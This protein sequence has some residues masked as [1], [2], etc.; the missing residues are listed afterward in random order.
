MN[1]RS[2]VDRGSLRPE[3]SAG[4]GA[5]ASRSCAVRRPSRTSENGFAP[6]SRPGSGHFGL[7]MRLAR[8]S[9][10]IAK[11]GRAE[12]RERQGERESGRAVV[13]D[14]T[15]SPLAAFNAVDA[16]RS[17]SAAGR[18]CRSPGWNRIRLKKLPQG[19][20][21]AARYSPIRASSRS[22]LSAQSWKPNDRALDGA[23]DL[24]PGPL[25]G[26]V[27]IAPVRDLRQRPR[28]EPVSLADPGPTL[29]PRP[30]ITEARPQRANASAGHVERAGD[31]RPQAGSTGTRRRWSR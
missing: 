22:S 17:A 3:S 7:P 25:Q 12:G 16:G 19:R 18:W 20:I 31:A 10:P 27:E 11:R 24:V 2:H 29:S 21:F 30:R 8:I 9:H 4:E 23:E 14:G 13:L 26:G 28:R 5:S 1:S 6:G 15:S